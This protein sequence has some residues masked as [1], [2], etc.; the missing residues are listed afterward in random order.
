MCRKLLDAWVPLGLWPSSSF[1]E[2]ATLEDAW[3]FS[4]VRAHGKWLG[5]LLTKNRWEAYP[6][7]LGGSFSDDQVLTV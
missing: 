7:I 3:N 5:K 6:A 1:A 4:G 2:A